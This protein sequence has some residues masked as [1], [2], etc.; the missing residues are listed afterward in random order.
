[1]GAGVKVIDPAEQTALDTKAALEDGGL[2]QTAGYGNTTICFTADLERG[3]RIAARMFDVEACTFQN[4]TL[5][6]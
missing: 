5:G 2:L 4:V 3:K 6:K 1:M